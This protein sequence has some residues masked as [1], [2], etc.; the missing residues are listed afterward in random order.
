[1]VQAKHIAAI[2]MAACLSG[3][4]Y[5]I[6]D[7]DAPSTT[8]ETAS[9]LGRPV[10]ADRVPAAAAKPVLVPGTGNTATP[11]EPLPTIARGRAYLFRGIAGLIFSLGMDELAQRI[12]RT[13]VTA[14][15]DTYLV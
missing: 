15:V 7:T 8:L 10:A 9:A 11:V 12:N 3:C 5:A 14:S 2:S 4:G 1:M 6:L 13:G